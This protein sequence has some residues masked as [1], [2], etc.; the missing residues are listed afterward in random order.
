MLLTSRGFLHGGLVPESC[1]VR[2]R[3]EISGE[4]QSQGRGPEEEG[5]THGVRELGTDEWTRHSHTGSRGLHQAGT[6]LSGCVRA[7][8]DVSGSES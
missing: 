5:E 4:A 7:T 1:N 2:L 6:A 3:A 8:C